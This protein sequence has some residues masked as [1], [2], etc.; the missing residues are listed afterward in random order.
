M[1][2]QWDRLF[3]SIFAM[4]TIV[5]VCYFFI[6]DEFFEWV[7]ARHHNVLS[8]YIR[9]LFIIL[10]VIGAY[11]KSF[12]IIFASIFALFTS[13]FWFPIPSDVD[14]DVVGFLNFEKNYLVSGWSVDKLFVAGAVVL[15]FVGL[16]YAAWQRK[17][18]FLIIVI[19]G[20][21]VLKVFHSV[22]FSGESGFSIVKPAL[23]G[24]V[25]CIVSIILFVHSKKTKK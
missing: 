10:I 9:P 18:K 25:V 24:V 23:L 6:S 2:T 14:A 11:K 15:F 1:N 7:F 20:S 16:I 3:G 21:A 5:I 17:W 4:A 19:A 12:T 8:W 22:L 13:M